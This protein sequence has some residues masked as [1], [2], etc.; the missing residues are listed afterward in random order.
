MKKPGSKILHGLLMATSGLVAST[1]VASTAAVAGGGPTGGSVVVGSA[2]IVNASPTQTVVNQS[3]KKALINWNSF[4]IPT[5]SSVKFNQPGSKSLA[6]NRVTGPNASTIDGQLL[7]NGNVWLINANGVLFGKGS[8]VNVGALLA[9]TSDITDSDFKNGNYAFQPA[10][11]PNAGVVNKGTIIVNGGGSAILS[12]PHVS[13]EGLIQADLGTVVLGGAKAFTVDMDGDNLLRYEITAPVSDAPSTPGG[14][15]AALVS[16]SGA[17]EAAGG[18]VIMTARAAQSVRDNAINNTGMIEANSVSVHNGEIDLDAGP[19]GTANVAGTLSAA[20]NAPGQTGGAVNVTAGTVTVADGAKIDVSGAAGGGTAQIGGGLHGQGPLAHANTVTVGTATIVADATAKGNGGTVAVWSDGATSFA[21]SVSAKGGAQGGNGGQVETSGHTLGVAS[22]AKV[23]TS[24]PLGLSGDWLLDPTNFLLTSN[25]TQGACSA[26]SSCVN[27][28]TIISNLASTDVTE[29]TTDGTLTLDTNS[30]I[31]WNSNH[32]LSL[33]SAGDM[34]IGSNIQNAGTGNVTLI[35]GWDGTT[36]SFSPTMAAGVYGHGNA[37]NITL[38]SGEGYLSVGSAGGQTL[39]AG[40]DITLN[41]PSAITQ[42]GYFGAGHG[43]IA[44]L[45][46]D[47]LTLAAGEGVT[48]T[49]QIGNGAID[50]SM[51]GNVS[52]DIYINVVNDTEVVNSNTTRTAYIGNTAPNGSTETGNVTVI[53]GFGNFDGTYFNNDLGDENGAGGDVFIGFTDSSGDDFT[54][55]MGDYDSSHNFTIAAASNLEITGDIVNAGTGNVTVIAGWDGQTTDPTALAEL[56]VANATTY[57]QNDGTVTV[58]ASGGSASIG[59]AGGVT[60]VAGYSVTVDGEDGAAQ[61]GYWGAGGGDINVLSKTDVT[62]EAGSDTGE[63]AQIGNGGAF[64][65][66]N[67]GNTGNTGNITV[68]ALNDVL[69]TGGEGAGAYAQIGNGGGVYDEESGIGLTGSATGEISITAGG[70]VT[71][72]G[73]DAE[74]FGS[75]GYAQIGNGGEDYSGPASGN[76]TVNAYGDVNVWG[77]TDGAFAQI[78]HGGSGYDGTASGNVSVTASN[79][80]VDLQGGDEIGDDSNAFGYAQIGNG[81]DGANG[82]ISGDVT[83][84]AA[85]CI[86]L[87]AGQDSA[88]VQ[89]GNGGENASGAFGGNISV[90]AGNDISLSGGDGDAYAQIGH[91]GLQNGDGGASSP[92]T[93]GDITVH[94]DGTVSLEGGSGDAYAQIGHGGAFDYSESQPG[95]SATGNISVT[96]GNLTTVSD[97]T[98]AAGE[99]DYAYAQIGNGGD[100]S[101]ST[102]SGNIVVNATG[103]VSLT[104]G[105]DYAQIGNGG[106]FSQASTGDIT[107]TSG[108]GDITLTAGNLYAQIGNGGEDLQGDVSGN[109]SVIS[110]DNISITGSDDNGQ[111]SGYAQ[112]GNGGEVQTDPAASGNITVVAG[113]DLTLTGGEGYAQIGNGA[114]AYFGNVSGNISIDVA[115]N[116]TF[117]TDSDSVWIGNY[118]GNG[119]ESGDVSI[120]TDDFNLDGDTSDTIG[121]FVASD[122][123]GGNVTLGVRD[124]SKA[125]TIDTGASYTSAYSLTLLAAGD[126]DITGQLQNAGSGGITLVA[127]WNPN[128][129]PSNVLTTAGAYGNNDAVLTIGGVT[130]GTQNAAVGSHGG[131]TTILTDALI[132]DSENGYAQ[133][134]YHGAGGG[135]IDVRSLGLIALTGN[136]SSATAQIGNGG[137]DVSGTITG[138]ISV[139]SAS[140]GVVIN[141]SADSAIAAIGNLGGAGSSESGNITVNTNGNALTLS[142]TNS[143]SARGFAAIGNFAADDTTGTSAGNIAINAGAVLLSATGG[144]SFAHIGNGDFH[145]GNNTGAVGGNIGINATSLTMNA[146][147]GNGAA[148]QSR[149]GNFGSGAVTGAI[150]VALTG[151]LTVLS[152]GQSVG[153]IG[154]VSAPLDSHGNPLAGI[155]SENITVQTGGAISLLGKN[156]GSARIESGGLGGNVQV[157]AAGNITL[158]GDSLPAIG[159]SSSAIIGAFSSG[160]STVNVSVIST[161]GSITLDAADPHAVAMIGTKFNG[162]PGTVRG[163]LLVNARNNVTLSATGTGAVAL[164]GNDNYGNAVGGNINVVAG[165][166]LRITGANKLSQG[167]LAQIGNTNVNFDNAAISGTTSGNVSVTAASVGGI[168]GSVVNDLPGGDFALNVFGTGLLTLNQGGSLTS[169]H[170]LTVATGGDVLIAASLENAGTGAISLTAAGNVTVGSASASGFAGFGSAGGPT[171]VNAK[172]IALSAVNGGAQIGYNGNSATGA[173]SVIASGNLSMSANGSSIARIGHSGGSGAVSGGITALA[174]GSITLSDNG[175]AIIGNTGNGTVSGA[176]L[177][178][179]N[180]VSGIGASILADL[181]GGDFTLA[182][183]G[184]GTLTI[185]NAGTYSSTHDLFVGAGGNIVVASTLANSGSGNVS[186]VSSKDVTIGGSGAGAGVSVGS[187]DGLTIVSGANILLSATNGYAQLGYHG[188]GSGAI[189]VLTAGNLTMSGGGSTGYYAQIGDGGYTVSGSSSP[190]ITISASGNVTLNAGAGQ[191][192]YAQ[193]GNGGAESNTGSSGYSE[194][195]LIT[196]S[197]QTVALNAG[198]GAGSYAQI[199]HGGYKAGQSLNGVATVGDNITIN[200]TSAVRLGGGGTDAY[201]QIGNG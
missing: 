190:P 185:D 178:D 113:G 118:T 88:F 59:S 117:V 128:V 40:Y 91:G 67:T 90:T 148:D 114:E 139:S 116:T 75:D 80:R 69:L 95:G 155:G 142:A 81:G 42:I 162:A 183:L 163:N 97:I 35:A 23:D 159:S 153:G 18:H 26:G 101:T 119:S 27:V 55:T 38:T 110:G 182:S 189:G 65:P 144:W 36:S 74:V 171:S 194:T 60:T 127:G 174:G 99:G 17:I 187:K 197:G 106:Y 156:G 177:V 192:A 140:Q 102:N 109:I 135:D 8:Q 1:V 154:G 92:E 158:A 96:A 43:N 94:A 45:A 170:N 107:V 30:D 166:A 47:N 181:P 196:V 62:V 2:T 71:A 48:G 108:D 24:A 184:S 165:N 11:N 49:E 29:S 61:I 105:S 134:G 123:L 104:G 54:W 4:S 9:T 173:I 126:L 121:E 41:A 193:I 151:G 168:G 37:G 136:T 85:T 44:V 169:S 57:G 3:S 22:S 13:N 180:S 58:Q 5:G 52:G 175:K 186:I 112:I 68:I 28:A 150:N 89:I 63:F 132:V 51:P 147:A 164:I 130:C 46:A 191:E 201:A 120:L 124:S 10:A 72:E 125:Y 138:N 98:L 33:L 50:G 115:G 20:G 146:V 157:T 25:T 133:I 16:N 78:G 77:G 73:Y 12:A 15:A 188:G 145:L 131:K 70:N 167:S 111:S 122:I 137:N 179:A 82:T 141:T 84:I 19:D 32:S 176:V 79:G 93:S 129:A 160:N 7:A 100:S 53:T 21:G 66:N 172:N 87:D 56:D 83:V 195:G 31:I 86:N 152:S 103:S 76:I 149:I 6:V 14:V 198:S 161:G 34:T 64:D 39:V 200:A 199:G 143:G